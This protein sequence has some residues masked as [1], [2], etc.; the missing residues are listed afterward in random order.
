MGRCIIVGAGELKSRTIEVRK[1]D[2]VI[3]ADAGFSHC[4]RMGLSPD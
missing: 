1:D 3:A 4:R 2:F